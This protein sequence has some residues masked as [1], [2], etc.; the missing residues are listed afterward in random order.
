MSNITFTQ[1]ENGVTGFFPAGLVKGV[2]AFEFSVQPTATAGSLSYIN[3]T[4]VV[5]NGVNHY[6]HIYSAT[7][8]P[9]ADHHDWQVRRGG[10]SMTTKRYDWADPSRAARTAA[11]EVAKLITNAMKFDD[12]VANEVIKSRRDEIAKKVVEMHEE[13]VKAQIA[14]DRR[15]A[16]MAKLEGERRALADVVVTAAELALITTLKADGLHTAEA[17]AAT[18]AVMVK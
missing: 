15:K 13:N 6:L 1:T 16:E 3:C 11:D 7:F 9:A 18:K 5:I 8:T 2:K 4:G 17:V 14:I 12:V 10:F